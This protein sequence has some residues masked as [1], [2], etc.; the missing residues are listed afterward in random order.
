MLTI[1]RSGAFMARNERAVAAASFV[2]G[3]VFD[4]LLVG[5]IDSLHLIAQQ[6]VYLTVI[7]LVLLQML[8]EEGAPPPEPEQM[9]RLR[10]LYF[11]YRSALV[12]FLL[13]TLLN[14]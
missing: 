9:S 7:T 14:M 11:D 3:F 8:R 10:R 1:G 6:T 2:A 4:L 5:R 13:G 12:H